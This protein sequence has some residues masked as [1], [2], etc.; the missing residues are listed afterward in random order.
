MRGGGEEDFCDVKYERP[1]L[2][3]FFCGMLGHGLKDYKECREEEEPRLKYGSWLK[4]LPWKRSSVEEGR[5]VKLERKT[6][7]KPLF[8]TKPK[9]TIFGSEGENP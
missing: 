3:F 4:V 7:A 5:N 2:F 1:P 9:K 8:I 6:C